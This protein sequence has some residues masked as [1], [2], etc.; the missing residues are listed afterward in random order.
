LHELDQ[1][2]ARQ[3]LESISIEK[4]IARLLRKRFD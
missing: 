2:L 3:V 1:F 4:R